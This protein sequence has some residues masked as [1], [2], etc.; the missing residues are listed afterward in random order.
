MEHI[1]INYLDLCVQ[2]CHVS[3]VSSSTYIVT[4][5]KVASIVDY[6]GIICLYKVN[7]VDY[8]VT[9]QYR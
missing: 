5:L 7:Q 8:T 6:K 3:T 9:Q 1:L 4:Y 2:C